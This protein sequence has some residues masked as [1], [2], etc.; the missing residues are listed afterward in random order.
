MFGAHRIF[1]G[2]FGARRPFVTAAL[3]AATMCRCGGG[4]HLSANASGASASAAAGSESDDGGLILVTAPSPGSSGASDEAS[5]ASLDALLDA[6]P[7]AE[8]DTFVCDPTQEPRDAAC[9][10]NDAYG[11]FV[12][13]PASLEGG[14]GGSDVA[15]TGTMAQPFATLGKALG[16]LN[17]K[18][19]VYVCAGVYPEEVS[20]DAAHAASLYGGLTCAPGSGGLT[21]QYVAGAVAEV[22][23]L[24]AD[25]AALT[26]SGVAGP[27]AVE[28]MGFEAP[29]A[30]GQDP[31]GAG[32]S[33]IAA[34]VSNST[35][36]FS[37][38]VLT[39]GDAASGADG[40]TQDNYLPSAPTAPP[41]VNSVDADGQTCPPGAMSP[42]ADGTTGGAGALGVAMGQNGSSYPPVVGTPP[43][44]GIGG[45]GDQGDY[46]AP[47]DDGADGF[48]RSAGSAPATLG[49]LSDAA[50]M[51]ASGGDG[52]AGSPGQGGGGG[53]RIL[54]PNSTTV[55]YFGG[56]G[57]MGG[58][59]GG[60]GSGGHGG[61]A[62]AALFSVNS[63]VTL[64]TCQLV[65]NQAGDGG[66]GGAGQ[67]GQAGSVGFHA[68]S[69]G[70]GGMG[71]NGA[72]GAGGGGGAGGLSAGIVYRGS[73]PARDATTLISLGHGTGG[74]AAGMG[75]S[76]GIG[77]SNTSGCAPSASAGA[78]GLSGAYFAV[79]DLALDDVDA[80]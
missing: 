59:G 4:S 2:S 17:G 47:G 6:S 80:P 22:R 60:G 16:N 51:P 58:C 56:A 76:A 19:R 42:P 67:P 24:A 21:W 79:D 33:S 34:W 28:D 39:A 7:A 43:R 18:S 48:V 1:L 66:A 8:A 12:A 50:W 9:I 62:S 61:G 69:S 20:I 49:T 10:L 5:D 46:G 65:S 38:V 36:S 74:G 52:S 70:N 13:S 57:G 23:P 77:G 14:L 26:I 32:L 75:G 11:V 40:A 68:L 25:H 72:G 29:M 55:Y 63:T 64:A 41:P 30:Q 54:V 73:E 45:L 78:A 53:G 37:R 27:L 15:G 31:S 35:V 3:V 44:D 71:G